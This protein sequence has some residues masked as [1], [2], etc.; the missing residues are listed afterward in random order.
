MG[1]CSRAR[2]AF[3][4]QTRRR[5]SYQRSYSVHVDPHHFVAL[6]VLDAN[7][8]SLRHEFARGYRGRHR[9]AA[10]APVIIDRGRSRRP[11]GAVIAPWLGESS[12]RSRREPGGQFNPAP[13]PCRGSGGPVPRRLAELLRHI[14]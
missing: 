5:A 4:E 12:A 11:V 2:T 6:A 10:A 7:L 1:S 3:G 14:V 13:R 8:G 9:A